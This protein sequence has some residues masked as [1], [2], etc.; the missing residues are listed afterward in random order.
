MPP[1]A[2]DESARLLV[3]GAGPAQLGVLAAARKRG[4]TIVAA[5]RDPSAP[6]FRYADRRAIVSIEDEAAI[7]RLA[8]AEQVDGIV[9]PGTDHAVATA[10]RIAARL[11]LPHP[12][13]PEAAV[14]AVSRQRQRER[15]AA[16]GL[17]QP[18]SVVCRTLDEAT[19]AAAELGYPVVVEAPDRSGER[20]VALAADHAAL[21]AAAVVALA[22]PRSEY[23][24]VEALV[25]GR[26]V[27]VNA[28]S[29]DGR[30]VPLT[31]TDREQAPPPA[32]GVP[33]VHLWPADLEPLEVGAA[34]E[35][36]AAAARALGI[37]HG[38]TTTQ[39][40]L[41]EE[42]ALLAKLS[43][44]VGGGHDAELCRVALGVDANALAVAAALGEDVHAHELAPSAR[45]GGA[46]VRF[47]VA[48]PGEL[49]EVRGLE[50]AAAVEGVRGIRSY[51][52]PGHVFRELRRASDRAG[53]ILATGD[54]RDDAAAAAGEAAGR[55]TFVVGAA[56][57]IA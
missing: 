21:T 26:V 39:V 16:A 25:P 22:E 57:A 51:R 2:L 29:L 8:R 6:G 9:A 27:T 56:K 54:T 46:C 40:I 33:L 42:G 53:A 15:L 35:T 14:L 11:A 30:F 38:P 18:R 13:T 36:A 1:V 43:A 23:C 17:P 49:R 37:E 45:V 52:K 50:R 12:V 44:R 7:D 48:P 47:L 31:V 10:A 4:L 32:F 41:G 3:L 34:V 55:I 5:D 24:L 19:A 20:G 28:F